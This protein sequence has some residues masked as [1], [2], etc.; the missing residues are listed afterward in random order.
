MVS[1]YHGRKSDLWV[2]TYAAITHPSLLITHCL[3]GGVQEAGAREYPVVNPATQQIIAS[4]SL[5]ERDMNERAVSY[6]VAAQPAWRMWP[7][8]RVGRCC[9]AGAI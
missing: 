3:L 6:A 9:A 7:E 2:N 4:V 5:M 8:A 1:C